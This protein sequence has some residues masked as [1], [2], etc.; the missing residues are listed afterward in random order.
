M[1][2]A[3][4][5]R[6][7]DDKKCQLAPMVSRCAA[8][9]T[10]QRALHAKTKQVGGSA[11]FLNAH[12]QDLSLLPAGTQADRPLW[13]LLPFRQTRCRE[14][15]AIA[16]GYIKYGSTESTTKSPIAAPAVMRSDGFSLDIVNA[17]TTPTPKMA[18]RMYMKVALWMNSVI[19]P[20]SIVVL[21]QDGASASCRR[22]TIPWETPVLAHVP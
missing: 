19:I 7:G 1:R 12:S 2:I 15:G 8:T 21:R 20:A 13:L 4:A 18:K 6:C 9:Q 14:S 3:V 11:A 10:V 17:S 16:P 22:N 5:G